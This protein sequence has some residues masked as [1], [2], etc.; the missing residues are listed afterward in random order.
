MGELAAELVNLLT[1]E[2]KRDVLLHYA[3]RFACDTLVETGTF[4]GD[5]V[6]WAQEHFAEVHSIELSP[7]L[8]ARACQRF[9]G[10]GNVRLYMGDSAVVLPVVLNSVADRRPLF[11]LDAHCSG[12]ITAG[13]PDHPPLAAELRTV[14]GA[15]QDVVVLIDDGR[16]LD[17]DQVRGDA[18]ECAPQHEFEFKD[19]IIRLTPK[20]Q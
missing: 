9:A 6:A 11:W 10:I 18:V 7:D 13:D 2:E 20:L 14:F 4:F 8:F 17:L 19:D 15:R 5:T 12:G 16:G 1:P 3:R